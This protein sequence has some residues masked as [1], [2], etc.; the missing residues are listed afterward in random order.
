MQCTSCGAQVPAGAA[1]C[2]N[3]GRVTPYQM[4]DSSATPDAPT[5]LSSYP[6]TSPYH[7]SAYPP[8]NPYETPAPPPPPPQHRRHP[9]GRTVLLLI[10]ALLLIGAGSALYFGALRPSIQAQTQATATVGAQRATATAITAQ[11]ATAT[12]FTTAAQRTT[13]TAMAVQQATATASVQTPQGMYD[14][15]T[16]GTPV[17]D[18]PL[19]TNGTNNWTEGTS[20]D[21]MYSCTFTGGAYHAS[22][23]PKNSVQLCVAQATN[24]GNLTYQVQ[25]T[26]V[27]GELGGIVF[28]TDASQTK[29][30]SFL[31]D[32]SGTYKLI[33]SV[34]NTGT[35]DQY[36]RQGTSTFINRSL[37]QPNL[38]TIIA[39]GSNIYLYINKQ[40]ITSASSTAYSSGS[41]GVFGGNYTLAPGDVAFSHA[42][43]WN[44]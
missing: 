3:C 44:A 40:Y 11:Q 34:D 39:R 27:K 38:L 33:T 9:V 23:Q 30:Y 7:S 13:A 15:A 25:M 2:P 42:Q 21:G 28:R 31:I 1:F 19:S 43:V 26:I 22:E 37:N 8:V 17:L 6:H 35:R 16:A 41:I 29:Y 4:S 12:A 20:S 18:D 32:R 10:L 36:L 14:Q 5:A 24:F